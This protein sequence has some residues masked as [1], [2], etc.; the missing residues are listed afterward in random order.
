MALVLKDRV[1]ETTT[2]TSTGTYT[3]AGAV[4]GYQSFSVVGDGNTTYY[5]VTDGTNWEVGIGTYTLSGTTLSRDTILES[6][7]AGSAVSWGAGSK[8]VFLT[9]PAEKA[10]TVDGVNPFT[11]PVLVNVDSAST[12]LEIRQIGTGNALLV[13]DSANPDSSPSVIDA[14]GNLI[15]GKTARTSVIDNKFEV[16]ST[17]SESLGGAPSA[18]FYNWSAT[19]SHSSYLSFFHYPSGVVGTT[20]TANASGD[21]LGRI[22]WYTQNGAGSL[23][24]ATIAGTTASDLVSVNLTYTANSHSFSGAITARITQRCNAQTTTAS[25]FAWNSDSYDQQSFSALA[26]ALTINADAGTPTDGQRA[27]FRIKDNGTA[28]ALTWTTGV[29][30]GFRAVGVTL[31]TTTVI[32]KTVYVGCIYNIADSRWD[33]VAVA[34]EA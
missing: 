6:S 24:A 25:P 12:A 27:V 13:E 32:N 2:T 19:A 17:G 30:K 9:Y 7:N 20:T 21:A 22:R 31:P 18:G 14:R 16:H 8:D 1:K 29:S 33:V 28:R 4:T 26:N 10:V 11:S 34:Q 5:T 3:L 23:F 15:L